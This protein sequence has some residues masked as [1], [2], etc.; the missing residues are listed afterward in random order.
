MEISE[1]IHAAA[2]ELGVT[3]QEKDH[4]LWR[5]VLVDRINDLLIHD[6]EKLVGILYRIDVSE[7]KLQELLAFNTGLDA[8]PIIADLVIE[9][10]V[11]KM[12]SRKQ[13]KMDSEMDDGE[14][15]W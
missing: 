5:A 1:A 7:K 10:Q 4:G 15:K 8:A 14:E 9:R 13:F 6:F 2:L 11:Q 3:L 12:N